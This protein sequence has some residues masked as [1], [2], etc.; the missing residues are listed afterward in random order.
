MI[1]MQIKQINRKQKIYH[2]LMLNKLVI[3]MP[4]TCDLPAII[5]WIYSIHIS[6]QFRQLHFTLEITTINK[7]YKAFTC[8]QRNSKCV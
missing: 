8:V 2:I 7:K 4:N 1:I 6:G 5:E 3:H